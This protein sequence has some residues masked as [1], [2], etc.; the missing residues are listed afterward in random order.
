MI[1]GTL[2]DESFSI[3]SDDEGNCYVTGIF[4]G[5][6]DI[7]DTTLTA[8][9][10]TDIFLLKYDPS[11]QRVWVRQAGGKED[12][13]S[14]AVHISQDG[15]LFLTGSFADTAY[16]EDDTLICF[17][18][19]IFYFDIFLA[20]YTLDGELI[21]VT[22]AGEAFWDEAFGV[23]SDP[24]GNTFITGSYWGTCKFDNFT[25]SGL[26]GLGATDGFDIF[27]AKYDV[28]GNAL[29]ANRMVEKGWDRGSD[30][31]SDQS[32]NCYVTGG[33]QTA[34]LFGGFGGPSLTTTGDSGDEDIFM[35]KYD[36]NGNFIWKISAGS[37][38]FDQARALAL[39]KDNNIYLTGVF[40]DTASFDS[41]DQVISYGLTDAFLAKYDSTGELLWV[42]GAGSSGEDGANDVIL[43][44]DGN[45]Y[46][47][48]YFGGVAHFDDL[49][50]IGGG[51]FIA[52]YDP[53]GKI[54]WVKQID[55]LDNLA[56]SLTLIPNG[57]L[58]VTGVFENTATFGTTILNGKGQTDVFVTKLDTVAVTGLAEQ[59]ESLPGIAYLAQ[60]YPNPFNPSTAIRYQLSASSNVDLSIYN[61][62]GQ[63]VA[64]LVSKRQVIGNYTV[65]FNGKNL[66]SGIYLYILKTDTWQ[67]VRKMVLL[68]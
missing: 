36:S 59:S 54:L 44:S 57:D 32:G 4:T 62:L 6:A 15:Y 23:C 21:W 37:V 8:R 43:D 28:N 38:D 45:T 48:G 52:K 51:L 60:N 20:K 14:Y 16:F 33:F 2:L 35:V 47:C 9:G 13:D 5:T 58:F 55:E 68:K 63:K 67:D 19:N 31:A 11:G 53:T 64:T 10:A 18:N 22:R 39:D 50:I 7:G 24:S 26:Y 65:E 1:G 25:L 17:D 41:T 3:D 30:V 49:Q 12:D 27:I 61:L 29:W 46:I 66:S 40:S 56:K 42:R 34:L